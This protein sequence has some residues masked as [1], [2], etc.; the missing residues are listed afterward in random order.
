MYKIQGTTMNKG[1]IDLKSTGITFQ[2]HQGSQ[3]LMVTY[4]KIDD[5]GE[6]VAIIMERLMMMVRRWR[7]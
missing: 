1:V 2:C 7:L 6:K 3:C 5:N 4:G